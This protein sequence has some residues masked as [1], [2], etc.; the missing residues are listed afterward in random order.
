MS[1]V[2]YHRR[3]QAGI[4]LLCLARAMGS[5]VEGAVW[6]LLR[7]HPSTADMERLQRDLVA[8]QSGLPPATGG[9]QH[10]RA[11]EALAAAASMRGMVVRGGGLTPTDQRK[12]RAVLRGKAVRA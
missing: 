9:P 1:V 6:D 3:D 12:V 11:H 8:V 4:D 2:D 10:G 5:G 7:G